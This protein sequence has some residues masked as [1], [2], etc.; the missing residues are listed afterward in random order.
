MQIHLKS[1][2]GKTRTL[3]VEPTDTLESVKE[4]YQDLEGIP[5]SSQRMVVA[6]KELADNSR[7]LTECNI[8][9]ESTIFLVLTLRSRQP[10]EVDP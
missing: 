6:G 3:T 4:R 9:S 5:I 7:T 8:A 2:T 1:L 10:A